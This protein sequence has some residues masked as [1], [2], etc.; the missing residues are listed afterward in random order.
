MASFR[1]RFPPSFRGFEVVFI[2]FV[3]ISSCYDDGNSTNKAAISLLKVT[4]EEKIIS[5]F[6]F[7]L[8]T[9]VTQ[10]NISH[11][12]KIDWFRQPSGGGTFE[13]SPH[14]RL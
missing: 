12:S 2:E 1:D 9:G 5:R 13:V 8:T 4:I 7:A 10:A 14:M 3:F 11:S 6:D